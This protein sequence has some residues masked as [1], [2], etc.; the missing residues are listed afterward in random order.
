[1]INN[2]SITVDEYIVNS[3]LINIIMKSA[4]W[5]CQKEDAEKLLNHLNLERKQEILLEINL[6]TNKDGY[7]RNLKLSLLAQ[8]RP[9]IMEMER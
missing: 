5:D 6:S 1:M 8:I 4:A 3:H 7:L 2:H 9:D